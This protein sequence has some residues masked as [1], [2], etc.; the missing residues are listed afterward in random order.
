MIA[1][2]VKPVGLSGIIK[3][4]HAHLESWAIC[5]YTSFFVRLSKV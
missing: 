5:E 4:C 1:R 3:L 2:S